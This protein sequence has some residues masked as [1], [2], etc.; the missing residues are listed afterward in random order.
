[1]VLNRYP[2]T[3]IESPD[4]SSYEARYVYFHTTLKGCQ[5]AYAFSSFYILGLKLF[6]K[7]KINRNIFKKLPNSLKYSTLI[8]IT[9]A[10]TMAY[11]RITNMPEKQRARAILLRYNINQNLVD[12]YMVIG[13]VIGGMLSFTSKRFKFINSVLMGG[14]VGFTSYSLNELLLKQYGY[15]IPTDFLQVKLK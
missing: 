8:G 13:W 1:M 6:K 9:I 4:R 11:N 3:P 5:I 15:N 14:F 12:D 2:E 10:N 7:E